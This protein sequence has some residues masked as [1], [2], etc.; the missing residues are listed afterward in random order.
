M[1]SRA[2]RRPKNHRQR[3][4]MTKRPRGAATA[5]G[6]VAPT[7]A[8]V[9]EAI[10]ARFDGE[11]SPL[12]DSVVDGHVAECPGCFAFETAMPALKRRM[13]VRI[14]EPTSDLLNRLLVAELRAAPRTA[15]RRIANG[16]GRGGSPTRGAQAAQL[17]AAAL[18]LL[19]AVPALVLGVFSHVHIVPAHVPGPCTVLLSHHFRVG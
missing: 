12:V 6:V 18:P 8:A 13:S 4:L 15:T 10:S 9:R 7:C 1:P 11:E 16:R 19:F 2:S 14:S 17:V 5:R 3:R